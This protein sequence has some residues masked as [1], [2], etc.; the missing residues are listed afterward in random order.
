[1]FKPVAY[2]EKCLSRGAPCRS[3]SG[4]GWTEAYCPLAGEAVQPFCRRRHVDGTDIS[5]ELERAHVTL[6]RVTSSN[7]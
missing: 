7:A 4:N 3:Q 2:A 1:M 5:T 6:Y